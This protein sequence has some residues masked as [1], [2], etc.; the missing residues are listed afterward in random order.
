MLAWEV[1]ERLT[2]KGV[3]CNLIT[4]Q[5]SIRMDGAK[6]FSSTVEMCNMN[7]LVE[8]AVLDEMQMIGDPDRGFHWTRALL[9]IP[10]AELHVC[11]DPSLIPVVQS[12]AR[13][14]GARAAS[15][16]RVCFFFLFYF[17]FLQIRIVVC[18]IVNNFCVFF[19]LFFFS[20]FKQYIFVVRE[21]NSMASNVNV[22]KYSRKSSQQRV[23]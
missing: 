9:G 14:T 16:R 15:T 10:A 5:E 7:R 22:P 3:A 8:V 17:F 6:H 2:G 21:L 19:L 23:Q 18:L 20:F 11:G 12:L 13:L 4:G 1:H